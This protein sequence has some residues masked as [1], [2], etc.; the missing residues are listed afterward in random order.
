[1]AQLGTPQKTMRTS[2]EQVDIDGLVAVAEMP[3]MHSAFRK[4]KKGKK[5]KKCKANTK[6]PVMKK[7]A[8]NAPTASGSVKITE[9]EV[10]IH[11]FEGLAPRRPH[12]RF[13]CLFIRC[14][15]V[16]LRSDSYCR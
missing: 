4:A 14:W 3:P 13:A 15:V 5:A 8:G 9:L 12:I 6:N 11:K 10:G 1:M 16:A 7:P 2:S